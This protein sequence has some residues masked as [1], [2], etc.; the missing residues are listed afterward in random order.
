MTPEPSAQKQAD[1]PDSLLQRAYS[2]AVDGV[3]DGD[4]IRS[5]VLDA[6]CEQF[7][8]LGVRRSTV[9][10]VA[11]RANVS[12]I[13]VYRR[14]AT[15][16]AL[17]EQVILREYRRYFDQFLS[18]IR[19]AHTVA[20]RV[21]LGFVG[22]LRAIRDNPIIGG[23]LAGEPD[24]LV[25]SMIS[26]QGRTVA[27]VREFVAG[28]LLHEQRARNISPDVDVELV[29]ELMVRVSASFLAIPSRLVDLN[30]EHQ[31]AELARHYLVPML[32]PPTTA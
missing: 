12:R 13:T 22:S 10:D 31:L 28:Q 14:F 18:E 9:D 23:L 26:D 4:D 7:S 27:M 16:D 1:A 21:V 20:D 6:A 24:M 32:E 3:G 29:A 5:R 19:Q 11:R 25:S 2:A 17:V 15:K 30:D 8:L